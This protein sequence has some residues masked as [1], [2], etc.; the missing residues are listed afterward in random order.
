MKSTV[1]ERILL[2]GGAGFIGSH[3]V[4]AI[5]Q[6]Y[7]EAHITIVDNYI[8]GNRDNVLPWL[9]DAQVHI[10]E[11]DATDFIWMEEFLSAAI[12]PWTLILHMASPA[13]PPRYQAEPVLTYLVN[14]QTTHQLAQYAAKHGARMLFASTSEV[15]GDPLKHPQKETYWGNV[16]PNGVRS[17]YDESKRLGETI[18]G[19]WHR[20]F[21]ADTRL[22]RI[23]NTYGPH[24]DPFDGRVIPDFCL[25]ALRG[26][27]INI[28][29]DGLQTRSFCY[30]EDL[31]AGILTFVADDD[32]AGETINLGNP[33]EFTMLELADKIEAVLGTE[34]QRNF[35]PLPADDPRRR[36]PDISKAHALLNWQPRVTLEQGLIPTIE[37]F[38]KR[39]NPS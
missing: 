9:D 38:K 39:I 17:C 25:R 31:V 24:M 11:H 27:P 22:I 30:V 23:F 2:T 36:Q 16:N 34:L 20:D 35:E 8:T 14:S 7:P 28:F 37:Y 32:L 3:L 13:S 6:Q 4:A 5:R 19:V 15:Y 33:D 29:G 1:F 21:G 26:E 10:V 18:C 12:E